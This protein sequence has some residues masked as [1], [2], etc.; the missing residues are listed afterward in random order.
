MLPQFTSIKSQIHSQ[1]FCHKQ[2]IKFIFLCHLQWFGDLVTMEWWDDLWLNEGFASFVEYLG[3]DNLHNDWK[4]VYRHVTKFCFNLYCVI[5]AFRKLIICR[6]SI[7]NS[8]YY[9]RLQSQDV[10]HVFSNRQILYLK[11]YLS[12]Q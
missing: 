11:R 3:A 4:M 5:C 12:A 7:L 1:Y 10:L 2:T 6:V 9:G 8:V